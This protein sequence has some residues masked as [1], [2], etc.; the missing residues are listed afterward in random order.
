MTNSRATRVLTVLA[1]ALVLGG[2]G[3]GGD[4]KPD[5]LVEG[6][7]GTQT[8]R[9]DFANTAEAPE[10]SPAVTGLAELVVGKG[11]TTV[12]I[13]VSGLTADTSYLGTVNTDKCS[14]SDPGGPIYKF[15]PSGKEEHP[16]IVRFEMGVLTNKDTKLAAGSNAEETYEK[17]AG[18][19]AR[20]VVIKVKRKAGANEDEADPPTLACADLRGGDDIG[21]GTSSPSPSPSQSSSASPKATSSPKGKKTGSPSPSPSEPS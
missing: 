3:K 6:E 19:D 20:S 12:D 5:P 7:E 15:D 13:L 9:G 4:S 21:S 10:G 17:A 2:C 16:N 18:P 8:F 14:A 11:R 1:A